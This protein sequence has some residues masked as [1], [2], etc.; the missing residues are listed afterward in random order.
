MPFIPGMNILNMALTVIWRQTI[1]YYKYESRAINDVGQDVTTYYPVV[2]L[3]GSWQPVP[4]NLY[5]I[6]GLDLQR[7]YFTFYTSNNILDITR[8]VSGDQLSFMGR[9]YQ[10]ESDNDWY[11][12]DGWKGVICVDLGVDEDV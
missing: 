5:I 6:Y 10:V 3:V 2:D 9:R 7:D 4:R 1:Q 12:L 8:D 11:Q